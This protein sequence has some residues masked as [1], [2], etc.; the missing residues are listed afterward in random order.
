MP[1]VVERKD[2]S[3]EKIVVIGIFGDRPGR[4]ACPT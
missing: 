1:E 4:E 2:V 3:E